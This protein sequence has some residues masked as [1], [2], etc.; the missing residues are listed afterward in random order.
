MARHGLT[1]GEWALIEDMFP[2]NGVKA[3]RPW[4]DH[5]KMIDAMLWILV[6]GAP[7][8]DLPKEFGPWQTVH[9]RFSRYRR[10]GTLDRILDRLKLKRNEQGKIDCGLFCIDGTNIRAARAAAG[11]EK[12]ALRKR[13]RTSP[14]TT[15]WAV[16]A[17]A[18]ARRSTWSP[19]ATR[20]PWPSLSRP[21]S[22]TSRR[23]SW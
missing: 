21:A 12:R 18:S 17:G 5:R 20:I 10:D 9:D 16:P 8:R 6:A 22:A 14:K 3:G 19:T 1:D 7:W 23:A 13:P 11:A 2:K 4:S 15:L